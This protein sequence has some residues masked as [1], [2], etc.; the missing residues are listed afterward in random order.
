MQPSSPPRMRASVSRTCSSAQSSLSRNSS[1]PRRSRSAEARAQ[2][3]HVVARPCRAACP[4]CPAARRPRRPR[5]ARAGAPPPA[6]RARPGSG[7]PSPRPRPGSCRPSCRSCSR[8]P[9]PCRR[10]CPRGRCARAPAGRG[11]SPPARR[12]RR[13]RTAARGARARSRR[14]ARPRGAG[15]AAG[16]TRAAARRPAPGLLGRDPEARA[17]RA[18]LLEQDALGRREVGGRHAAR[19]R[20]PRAGAR[21]CA[22]APSA[23]TDRAPSP[24]DRARA[25]PGAGAPP[26]AT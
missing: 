4:S 23:R 22:A 19:R 14:R 8:S 25:P 20:S 10:S 24:R 3:V 7:S 21:S 1:G 26:R 15:S 17:L 2:L 9:A 12:P 13:S 6:C 5:A 16:R 18:Q 11:R